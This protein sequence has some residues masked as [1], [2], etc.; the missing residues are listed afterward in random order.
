MFPAE[1][2]VS[3]AV[4]ILIALGAQ[5]L[6]YS[7]LL[8]IV[9]GYGTLVTL[10]MLNGGDSIQALG[11]GLLSGSVLTHALLGHRR[12]NNL[13]GSSEWENL[14]SD[15]IVRGSETLP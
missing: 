10:V 12:R 9:F 7:S 8:S 15:R 3:A 14:E 1:G 2:M 5:K 4:A 13:A 11:I 6:P